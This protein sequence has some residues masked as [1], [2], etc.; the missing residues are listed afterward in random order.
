MTSLLQQL[1]SDLSDIT[2]DARRSL[3]Q[4]LVGRGGAGAGTIWHSDG[5]IVTNAHVVARGGAVRVGLSDGR[6]FPATVL[7][8]DTDHDLAA[9]AVEANDLPTAQI[10]ES[11][12]VRAGQWVMALGHPWGIVD[13]VTGG[14]VIGAGPDLIELRA[15]TGR[16]WVAVSLH[17]RP[18]HSG[19]PLIDVEGRI[20]GINTL[21]TGP[22]VGAAVPVDTVKHFLKRAI[23]SMTPAPHPNAA[24][25]PDYV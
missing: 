1:N 17:L 7:A 14:V 11:R 12:S 21:M 16:D 8:R 18:G 19:G 9:L 2:E 13:A 23:G 20:I 6:V 3:V 22:E 15:M 24:P 25:T 5:L 10:G 4:V